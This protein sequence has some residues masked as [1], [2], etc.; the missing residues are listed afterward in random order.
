M[1]KMLDVLV[2]IAALWTIAQAASTNVLR[3]AIGSDD[4]DKRRVSALVSLTT[5][6]QR[7]RGNSIIAANQGPTASASSAGQTSTLSERVCGRGVCDV[8]TFGAYGDGVHDDTNALTLAWR[9]LPMRNGILLV[10]R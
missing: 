9:A 7:L 8:T 10:P 6:D 1:R 5:D 2:A 4:I 3:T